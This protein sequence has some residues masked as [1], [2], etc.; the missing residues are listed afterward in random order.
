M[1]TLIAFIVILSLLVFVHE[2][3]HFFVARR[4][5]IKALEFGFG[6]PPRAVGIYKD[7]NG[8]WKTVWGSKDIE[9]PK[10][11]YSINW[12]PLGGFVNIKGEAGDN[13][14][15]DSFPTKKIWQRF[16]VLVAGV[17][18]NMVLAM[19]LLCIGFAIGLPQEIDSTNQMYQV[20]PAILQVIMIDSGSPAA[21]AGLKLGDNILTI[22]NITPATVEDAQNL[23]KT[24]GDQKVNMVI[25][26]HDQEQTLQIETKYDEQTKTKRIGIA[27]SKVGIVAYPWY[28]AIPKGIK[29]TVFITR[30]ILAAFY[31][32]LHRL[33]I[34]KSIS[35]DVAGPV[36]IAV[37]T[38]QVVDLGWSYILQFVALLSI[39]LAIINILPFPAL[40]GGRILFL[41]IEKI[42][43][44]PAN[45]KIE[46]IV[47]GV[48]FALLMLLIAFVTYKDIARLSGGLWTKIMSLF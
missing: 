18:M 17:T 36:G 10:T 35:A 5:G 47:H 16:T 27:L 42:R 24:S 20:K 46:A 33:F 37:L 12:I 15:P 19:V 2:W 26:R 3:G 21:Q 38:G 34:G 13:F 6:F 7:E 43:R 22:N 25:K 40:D 11:I 41:I 8:K 48:G 32:L 28:L 45:Q 9:A 1:I 23:I 39:N 30:D 44:K 4:N 29:A 31:D 14:D